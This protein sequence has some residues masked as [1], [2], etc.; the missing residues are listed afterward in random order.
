MPS[1]DCSRAIGDALLTRL[2]DWIRGVGNPVHALSRMITIFAENL[3]PPTAKFSFNFGIIEGGVSVNSIAPLARTRLD[4]RAVDE[5][6]LERMSAILDAYAEARSTKGRPTMI[7]ARTVKG[8][9][10]SSIEGKD[11]WHGKAFKKG[12]EMDA[13]IAELERQVVAVPSS[14]DLARSIPKPASRHRP[15]TGASCWA[16]LSS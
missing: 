14:V 5:A 1:G 6:L 3:P 7:V 4:L 12:P 2:K 15:R 8:K 9:G 10:V 11:G 16:S 13:A